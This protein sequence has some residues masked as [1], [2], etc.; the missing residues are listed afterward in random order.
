MI[1]DIFIYLVMQFFIILLVVIY[2]RVKTN[3]LSDALKKQTEKLEQTSIKLNRTIEQR[4]F[5]ENDR[6]TIQEDA[7]KQR[8]NA[9]QLQ[10]QLKQ[11]VTNSEEQEA[12]IQFLET[13]RTQSNELA[14][15]LHQMQ[16]MLSKTNSLLQVA[17]NDKKALE[18]RLQEITRQNESLKADYVQLS[19]IKRQ[20]EQLLPKSED[21]EA[22]LVQL[23]STNEALEAEKKQLGKQIL[24]QKLTIGNLEKQVGQLDTVTK[25]HTES[26][27]MLA[28][29][30][31]EYNQLKQKYE[32]LKEAN[33]YL[34]VQ[35]AEI[36]ELNASYKKT[37][38]VME[39]GKYTT[40][41]V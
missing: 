36:K 38:A 4:K 16:L 18:N 8:K 34:Q 7:S 10:L 27:N 3:A 26:Q 37:I 28:M 12:R 2:Y 39:N 15:Q 21:M 35:I 30:Q 41:K 25:K 1:Y 29:L 22:N 23:H 13:Y 6:N 11:S 5:L 17:E 9:E 19:Q 33:K 32:L 40:N 20:Y 24:E 31:N 14:E